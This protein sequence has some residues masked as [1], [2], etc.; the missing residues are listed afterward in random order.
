MFEVLEEAQDA[1]VDG[2]DPA[3]PVPD[4]AQCFVG[5][6]R[7]AVDGSAIASWR[8]PSQF[9]PWRKAPIARTGS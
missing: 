3:G 7:V 5:S 1:Q 6:A 9:R 8:P 2:S 4:Q